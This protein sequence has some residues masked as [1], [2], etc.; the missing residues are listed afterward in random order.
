[1]HADDE[2]QKRPGGRKGLKDETSSAPQS[3]ATC[4]SQAASS[5]PASCCFT[6]CL[7]IFGL[8]LL[9]ISLYDDYHIKQDR[10]KTPIQTIQFSCIE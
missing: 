1:M 5:N 10:R 7:P 6:I 9:G 2:G 8:L 4:F 3:R